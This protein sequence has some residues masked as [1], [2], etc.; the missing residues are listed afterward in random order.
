MKAVDNPP[1]INPISQAPQKVRR[2]LVEHSMAGSVRCAAK[3]I[4]YRA[5]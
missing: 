4:I 3:V 5:L 2:T 1:Q